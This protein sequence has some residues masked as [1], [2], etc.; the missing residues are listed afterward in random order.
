MAQSLLGSSQIRGTSIH[1]T[2]AQVAFLYIGSIR[3]WRHPPLPEALARAQF[4][5]NHYQQRPIIV[6]KFKK[7]VGI[8]TSTIAGI[9]KML[10]ATTMAERTVASTSTAP[11]FRTLRTA[12]QDAPVL[13]APICRTRMIPYLL[14]RFLRQCCATT[15]LHPR[16]S[17]PDIMAPIH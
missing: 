11:P 9:P 13:Q 10:P 3:F 4:N 5:Q 7:C 14:Y 16:R 8:V 2:E 1:A 15:R 6:P 12:Q 17:K